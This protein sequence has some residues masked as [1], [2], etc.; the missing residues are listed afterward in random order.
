MTVPIHYELKINPNFET[1]KFDG[2]TII[3]L[4]T[5]VFSS[6]I[7]LNATDMVINSCRL[8]KENNKINLTYQL[9]LETEELHIS[10]NELLNGESKLI[11]E[12]TGEINDKLKGFYQTKYKV[13]DVFHIGAVT[14]FQTEDA[15]RAFPCF[16]EPC[17][18]SRT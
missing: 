11:I 13:G 8:I 10:L 17:T 4:K 2:R 5:E 18:G 6:V 3:Y 7:T 16:D 9:N 15:R 1:F 12:Y 14:K